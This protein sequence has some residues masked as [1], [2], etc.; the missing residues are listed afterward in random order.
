MKNNLGNRVLSIVMALTLAISMMLGFAKNVDAKIVYSVRI[1]SDITNGT[2]T[3][4]Q[5]SGLEEGDTITL[6][7]T[8]ATGYK[9]KELTVNKPKDIETLSDLVDLMGDATFTVNDDTALLKIISGDFVAYTS[10]EWVIAALDSSEELEEGE[11]PGEFIAR[12]AYAEWTFTCYGEVIEE[13]CLYDYDSDTVYYFHGTNT[14]S[15]PDGDSVTTTTVE[16]GK[17]YT[18]TMPESDVRVRAT[19][20]PG[21]PVTLTLHFS[22]IDGDD[23]VSPIV[24]KNIEPGTT[25]RNA[26]RAATGKGYW[27]E[28]FTKEGYRDSE[29][30]TPKPL[31]NYA[32]WSEY[33]AAGLSGDT[34]IYDDTDLYV[35]MFKPIDAVEITVTPPVCGEDTDTPYDGNWKWKEQTNK[36]ECSLP[37]E[38][39][40]QMD[41]SADATNW[42]DMDDDYTPFVGT[43]EGGET[44]KARYWLQ[45]KVGYYFAYEEGEYD[46]P[47]TVTVNGGTFV[48]TWWDW[49]YLAIVATLEAEHDWGEWTVIQEPTFEEEGLE[50]R[51]CTK[52]D[53]TETRPISKIV[54]ENTS[55]DGSTWEKGSGKNLDFTFKRS[56]DD[57]VTYSQ[58]AGIQ[59]D[60]KDVDTSNYTAR[61]GSVIVSLK[62][63]YLETLSVGK[64]TITAIFRDGNNPS[65]TFTITAKG[66]SPDTSD[67][68]NTTLWF[69]ILCGAVAILF[70][71]INYREKR[72]IEE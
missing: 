22:S 29:N 43:F 61:E 9:L 34:E 54:Y 49:D 67:Q 57:S 3:A 23:L 53:E 33:N 60:G 20:E 16:E 13:I 41:P 68:T 48:E 18:F 30:R 25:L 14:G 38:N 28:L 6:T 58:F 55:G 70:I 7:V 11:F 46:F 37:S 72:M 19:F 65:A 39:N 51:K 52:C 47:G 27:D 8:P 12:T 17:T 50:Q 62:P 66:A 32:N 69:T 35:G 71:G 21:T 45:S 1:D 31:S 64:H 10:D 26:I 24:I 56:Y 5:T 40:Y 36:P 2:V 44:Y 59:I 63:A 42:L 4:D 15:L